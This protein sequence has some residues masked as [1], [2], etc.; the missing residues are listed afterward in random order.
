[1]DCQIL[2]SLPSDCCSVPATGSVV[3]RL[4]RQLG[5][6]NSVKLVTALLTGYQ[7][8]QNLLADI[9]DVLNPGLA[10]ADPA[11]AA[12]VTIFWLDKQI[13][14]AFMRA[15]AE[16]VNGY[17]SCLVI[18]RI[19]RVML[20]TFTMQVSWASR[21][22]RRQVHAT[23]GHRVGDVLP[24]F[25]KPR[26]PPYRRIDAFDELYDRLSELQAAEAAELLLPPPHQLACASAS[27]PTTTTMPIHRFC[28]CA[29]TAGRPAAG[30]PEPFPL[31]NERLV[32]EAIEA[33]EAKREVDD[34]MAA[35]SW[36]NWL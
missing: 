10:T 22:S 32:A 20:S 15:F 8:L 3:V 29:A 35:A 17:R 7:V 31:L 25:A 2:Q 9:T 36:S 16:I 19:L 26:R 23:P 18:S 12:A 24:V 5:I 33:E 4:F 21:P 11:T 34:A 14:A 6:H 30:P 13:R 1:F 27:T 28:K